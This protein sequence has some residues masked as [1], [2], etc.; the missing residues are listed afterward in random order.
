MALTHGHTSVVTV[1]MVGGVRGSRKCHLGII[2]ISPRSEQSSYRAAIESSASC[3][4][5]KLVQ[6]KKHIDCNGIGLKI[7]SSRRNYHIFG[8]FVWGDRFS[9]VV[10]GRVWGGGLPFKKERNHPSIPAGIVSSRPFQKPRQVDGVEA[11]QRHKSLDYDASPI[12]QKQYFSWH[13]RDVH[14]RAHQK[15]ALHEEGYSNTN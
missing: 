5:R 1:L 6:V 11:G 3:N 10:G 15:A 7:S 9:V 2:I 4:M 12:K 8:F 13:P 14:S